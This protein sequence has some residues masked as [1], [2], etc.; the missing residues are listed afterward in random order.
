M[1]TSEFKEQVEKMG[2]RTSYDS[3][4]GDIN[5]IIGDEYYA[6]IDEV[7]QYSIKIF[8]YSVRRA[9]IPQPDK[10]FNLLVEYAKTP[11]E[12]RKDEKK[13]LVYVPHTDRHYL[14][15]KRYGA[16]SEYELVA[17]HINGYKTPYGTED[18][19]SHF[20]FTSGEMDKYG[21]SNYQIE[22]VADN[23][24]TII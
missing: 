15:S 2:F 14:Y 5:I 7:Y 12:Q 9:D 17:N 1:R 16:I 6:T 19:R 21:I 18:S 4:H 22:E 20:E 3:Y 11:I 8:P 24:R 13:Y 10:F 23:A